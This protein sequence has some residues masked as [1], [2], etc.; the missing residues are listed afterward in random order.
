MTTSRTNE[1][2]RK[3]ERSQT[4]Y[5]AALYCGRSKLARNKWRDCSALSHADVDSPSDL[6]LARMSGDKC[7]NV[8]STSCRSFMMPLTGVLHVEIAR[9]D[10]F[11]G[12]RRSVA[13]LDAMLFQAAR[14]KR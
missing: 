11:H 10:R 5:K 14:S 6:S 13:N 9:L 7:L 3:N 12:H 1:K 2:Q 8:E 4:G